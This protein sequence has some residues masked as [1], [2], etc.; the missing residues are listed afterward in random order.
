[1][2]EFVDE[3]RLIELIRANPVIYTVSKKSFKDVQL[4][5]NCW[6]EISATLSVPTEACKQKWRYLRDYYTRRRKK[7]T[8][9][10]ATYKTLKEIQ[11]MEA[12]SFLG[13]TLCIERPTLTNVKLL[14]PDL[15]ESPSFD[16]TESSQ[17]E[18]EICIPTEDILVIEQEESDEGDTPCKKR[19]TVESPAPSCSKKLTARERVLKELKENSQ[20]RTK[21]IKSL[22]TE[23]NEKNPIDDFCRSAASSLKTLPHHLMLAAKHE[24]FSVIAKYEI[25]ALNDNK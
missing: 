21:C 20:E 7:P 3:E 24:I 10:A 16:N 13:N 15:D 17:D 14:K 2:A 1:M 23:Q 25:Q 18:I 5:E 19:K 4:K 9:T 6:N 11:R 8:G 12:L 22:L